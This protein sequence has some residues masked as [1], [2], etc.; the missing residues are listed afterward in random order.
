M[1][2]RIKISKQLNLPSSM[3]SIL[4]IPRILKL[5]EPFKTTMPVPDIREEKSDRLFLSLTWLHCMSY[6]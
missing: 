6:Y 3:N 4:Q 1:I 5:R 2:S